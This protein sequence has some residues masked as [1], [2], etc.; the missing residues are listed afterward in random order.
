M[1]R[2]KISVVLPVRNEAKCI[3]SSLQMLLSQDFPSDQFELLVVDGESTD[4]T[5]ET[6]QHLADEHPQ[7]RLL[8]NPRRLSSSGRNIGVR[9]A[10]G[11]LIVVVDGHCEI[12]TNRYFGDLA[13]AFTNSEIDVV[14]RPQPLTTIDGSPL[15]R[16]IAAARSTWVGHHPDS[17]IYSQTEQIAP[18]IS[19][20][21]A[22]RREVFDRVGYFDEHFDAC[23]DVDFNFRCD[24]AGLR[25][26]FLP[27]A[28]VHYQPRDTL[29][30]LFKQLA[31]YGRGR[32]RFVRKHPATFS[33]KS[34]APA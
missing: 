26:L 33:W 2:P 25:C 31:R 10:R 9:H 16:A 3:A 18:A 30:G 20:G 15:Q 14:G 34:F 23:E 5:R 8:Q 27:A 19:V 28:A 24:Q 17:L 6:V 1:I 32:V 22:Y 4:T 21:A 29:S 12:P 7:I 11:E 13:K